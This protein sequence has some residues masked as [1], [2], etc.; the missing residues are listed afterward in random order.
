MDR[1][2]ILLKEND[3]SLKIILREL[4][5][6]GEENFL[7]EYQNSTLQNVLWEWKLAQVLAIFSPDIFDH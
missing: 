2:Y 5:V 3:L 7:V 1:E 4:L 6:T